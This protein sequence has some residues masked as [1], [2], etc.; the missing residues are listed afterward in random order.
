MQMTEPRLT[1][2]ET[3]HLCMLPSHSIGMIEREPA[4]FWPID[5]E[6]PGAEGEAGLDLEHLNLIRAMPAYKRR[7]KLR[8]VDALVAWCSRLPLM[9]YSR[10]NAEVTVRALPQRVRIASGQIA[11]MSRQATPCHATSRQG[12]AKVTHAA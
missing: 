12:H 3:E 9:R 2:S 5:I 11:D 10:A 7:R 1:A 4:H 6:E 8:E